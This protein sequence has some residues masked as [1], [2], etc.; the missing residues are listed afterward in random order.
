MQSLFKRGRG[1]ILRGGCE[2]FRTR[3]VARVNIAPVFK[4]DHGSSPCSAVV[5]EVR[6]LL[7]A[8]AIWC[9]LLMVAFLN[10]AFEMPSIRFA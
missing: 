9:G 3:A 4:A 5:A 8:L 2:V 7:R 10:G 1:A 6:M